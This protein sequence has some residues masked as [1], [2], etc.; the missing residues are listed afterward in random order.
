[1]AQ[2]GA[3]S[4]LVFRHFGQVTGCTS[5]GGPD[6]VQMAARERVKARMR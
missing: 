3:R 2:N 1:V 5:E 4:W 6:A